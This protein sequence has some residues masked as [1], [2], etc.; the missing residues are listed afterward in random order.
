MFIKNGHGKDIPIIRASFNGVHKYTGDAFSGFR[1]AGSIGFDHE[2]FFS[3]NGI[4][5]ELILTVFLK[6]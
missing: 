1:L 5:G 2:S 6:R 4:V 3:E